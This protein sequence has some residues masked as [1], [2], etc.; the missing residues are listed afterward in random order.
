MHHHFHFSSCD[1]KGGVPSLCVEPTRWTSCF[2][3]WRSC[4]SC[5][6][7][8]TAIPCCWR[9]PARTSSHRVRGL[10]RGRLQP[11][12]L[13]SNWRIA[14][15]GWSGGRRRTWPNQRVRR[16][17]ARQDALGWHVRDL[18]ILLET[19]WGHLMFSMVLRALLSKPSNLAAS[20]LFKGQVSEP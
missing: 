14:L 10:P 8:S 2:Q 4:A 19:R 17:A 20:V 18:R 12:S 11:A 16:C 7:S 13:G 15:V 5:S 6:A 9:S 3:C 1:G